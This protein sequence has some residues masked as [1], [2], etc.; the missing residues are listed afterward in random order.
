[1]KNNKKMKIP[2]NDGISGGPTAFSRWPGASLPHFEQLS[3]FER[4]SSN[5]LSKVMVI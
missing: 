4:L 1:M 2:L 5:Y 3:F